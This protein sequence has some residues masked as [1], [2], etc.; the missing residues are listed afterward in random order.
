MGSIL[1]SFG[2]SVY[3][4]Y[5]EATNVLVYKPFKGIIYIY[6]AGFYF[7]KLFIENIF[8]S[9]PIG[10]RIGVFVIAIRIFL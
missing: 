2:G 6:V 4:R 8:Y 5:M 9:F 3:L 1:F 10:D 7:L